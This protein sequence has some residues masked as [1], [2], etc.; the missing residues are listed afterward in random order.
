MDNEGS[1]TKY[2]SSYIIHDTVSLLT[3]MLYPCRSSHKSL[4]IK[5]YN[6]VLCGQGKPKHAHD[7]QVCILQKCYFQAFVA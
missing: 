1:V 2:F 7:R 5:M 3:G 4:W 6:S